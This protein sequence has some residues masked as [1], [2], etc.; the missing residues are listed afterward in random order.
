M[1]SLEAISRAGAGR[2]LA[3]QRT[4]HGNLA[5]VVGRNIDQAVASISEAEDQGGAKQSAIL[6]GLVLASQRMGSDAKSVIARGRQEA[7]TGS[8]Q[9]LIVELKAA[10]VDGDDLSVLRRERRHHA[11]DDAHGASS[12]NSLAAQWLGLAMAVALIA[13]RKE[14]SVS[15]AVSRTKATMKFR[16]FRTAST[17]NAQAWNAEHVEAFQDALDGDDVLAAAIA[18]FEL[19]RIWDAVLDSRTCADCRDH[20]GEVVGIDEE[21][22]GGDEPTMH[23][24][25]RCVVIYASRADAMN[26]RL[27]DAA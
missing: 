27:K 25:C 16:T 7:R 19:V 21:F 15:A 22:R 23:A 4:F 5:E 17:E 14:K 6:T 26:F 13:Q 20:D 9:R 1:P 11:A 10:G 8:V 2:L 12:G 3:L 18:D 24:N